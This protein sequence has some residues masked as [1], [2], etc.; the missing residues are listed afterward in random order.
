LEIL[1]CDEDLVAVNKPAG[2]LVHRSPI[3]PR[4]TRFALQLL[5]DQLGHRVY[6][7]HRLDKPTSGILLFGQT[8]EAAA[9]LAGQFAHRSA[10]KT[11][12]AIVRGWCPEQGT[13]EHPLTESRD[14]AT[15]FGG[16]LQPRT[17]DAV[18]LF[19]RLATADLPIAVD[20][21][22]STRYSLVLLRPITGR[23]H[24]LRRHLKHIS[25]P[26]IGDANHGKGI[27]NRF[28]QRH[29]NCHRL[30]LAC[31]RLNL[32][33]PTQGCALQLRARP[34]SEFEVVAAALGWQSA[35]EAA[36]AA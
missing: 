5:R 18:T 7:V 22:P 33:H 10:G 35:L 21:Y 23:R 12:I 20:R 17:Q 29:F 31:I 11:Y 3:D 24:Q 36:L 9:A 19:Q 16:P 26:I 13:I 25:H 34:G 28:F 8:P 1:H 4:E 2:L 6:P 32:Q 14:T 15:G 27:H 30:L